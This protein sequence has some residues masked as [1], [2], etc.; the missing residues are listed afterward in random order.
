MIE[1]PRGFVSGAD[2]QGAVTRALAASGP[3][4]DSVFSEVDRI[5]DSSNITPADWQVMA[6]HLRRRREEFD[7]FVVLHGTNTLAHSA[8]AVSFTLSGFGKAVVFTGSQIPLGLP[9]SDAP[10]NI[11]GAVEEVASGVSRGA[12]SSSAGIVRGCAGDQELGHRAT[13][14]HQPKYREAVPAGGRGAY[15]RVLPRLVRL[16]RPAGVQNPG[17]RRRHC[18][19]RSDREP[20]PLHDRSR[21]RC[22][23]LPYVRSRRRTERGARA[24]RGRQGT[25]GIRNACRGREPVPAGPDR[26]DQ[27]C[28]RGGPA[29][30]Q[31]RRRGGHDLRSRARQAHVPAQPRGSAGRAG[32][33]ALWLSTLASEI[34]APVPVRRRVG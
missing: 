28:R 11:L 20:V 5:V 27:V 33:V 2:V 21:A 9:G 4:V 34:T 14:L 1:S 12:P 17:H 6:D 32:P 3:D 31:C 7:G 23:D 18:R 26:D 13:G 25:G 30:G 15:V 10:T 24:V 16:G 29:S 19:A 22:G 8:A